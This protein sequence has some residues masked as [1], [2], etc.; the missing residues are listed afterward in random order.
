MGAQLLICGTGIGSGKTMVGCALA[1][2]FKVRGLRVGVMK[3]IVTGA[4]LAGKSVSANDAEALAAAAWSELP[5]E[6]ISPYR[7]VT[8][9]APIAA[10]IAD[11][12]PPPDYRAIVESLRAIQSSN[13]AVIVEE[14]WR[15]DASIDE[16]HDYASLAADCGLEL[17]IVAARRDGFITEAAKILDCALRRGLRVRGTILNCLAPASP[18]DVTRDAGRLAQAVHVPLLGT[19][20]Y[21][22]P[23][24]LAIVHNLI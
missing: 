7:Y 21:K 6:R 17:I 16:S 8:S 10:A 11:G 5:L 1:F 12:T 13:D 3:P 24:G 20:R 19:V 14:V 9:A 22:E 15:L 23:L 2:A 18:A 4:L